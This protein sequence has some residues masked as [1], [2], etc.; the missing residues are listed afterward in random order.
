MKNRSENDNDYSFPVGKIVG[1]HGLKG[2]VKIRPETNN[3]GLLF[4]IESVEIVPDT[5]GVP[6]F[7]ADVA[8]IRFDKRILFVSFEGYPD[9]TS[10]EHLFNA[11]V[12]TSRDQ[13]NELDE[14]EWWVDDLIGLEV[15]TTEGRLIGTVSGV[16]GA[17]SELLEVAKAGQKDQTCLVPFVSALVP[18]VDTKAK[19][20]EVVDLPGLFD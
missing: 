8:T 14:D 17:A 15:Y 6:R 20:I 9:R 11:S 10:V 7:S 19:R 2:E 4:D 18:L 5:E 1:F 13:L 3:P 16:M 12:Y